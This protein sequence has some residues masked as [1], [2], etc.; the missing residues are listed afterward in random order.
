M[1]ALLI[2][3]LAFILFLERGGKFR[4]DFFVAISSNWVGVIKYFGATAVL[5]VAFSM[6]PSLLMVIY[7]RTHGFFAYEV[8]GKEDEAINVLSLNVLVN[9]LGLSF[10]LF[11]FAIAAKLK[12]AKSTLGVAVISSLMVGAAFYFAATSSGQLALAAAMLVFCAILAVLITFWVSHGMQDKAK[13]WGWPIG[14]AVLLLL[15]PVIFSA[16]A[17]RLTENALFQ[18][19]V[20]GINVEISE[21]LGLLSEKPTQSYPARLLLRTN[22]FYYLHPIARPEDIVIIKTDHVSI[23]YLPRDKFEAMFENL[24]RREK[25]RH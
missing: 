22:D 21:P 13:Y 9:Y 5:T 3:L 2:G 24:N 15:L 4:D 6:L 23:R 10:F 14:I 17:S 11:V 20:G 1:E 7:M 25:Q 8:F 16:P 12:T 19:K 18:M